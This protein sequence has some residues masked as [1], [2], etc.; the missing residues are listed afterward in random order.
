MDVAMKPLPM[1]AIIG[2]KRYRTE[3]ATLIASDAYWDGHNWERAGTNTFLFRTA[4]GNYFAQHRYGA[5]NAS[6]F[7]DYGYGIS[8]GALTAADYQLELLRLT[9]PGVE[10]LYPN[11]T[12]LSHEEAD[13]LRVDHL[14]ALTPDE[15]WN[16]Y[17]VLPEHYEIDWREAFPDFDVED[18]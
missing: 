13:E 18:A 6:R 14:R 10:Q 5:G 8:Q 11:L 15:A 16:L 3:T 9:S 7:F 12:P 1:E 17:C 2:G 4:R